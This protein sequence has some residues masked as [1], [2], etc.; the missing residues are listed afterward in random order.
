M[1]W[2]VMNMVCY[3]LVCYERDLLWTGL[4]WTWSVIKG[5]VMN[6]SVLSGLLWAGLFWTVTMPRGCMTSLW[7]FFREKPDLGYN[8]QLEW[9]FSKGCAVTTVHVGKFLH[10]KCQSWPQ[11]C[12]KNSNKFFDPFW[13]WHRWKDPKNGG[14]FCRFRL[15]VSTGVYQHKGEVWKS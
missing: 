7:R 10:K 2:S 13:G 15:W 8:Q 1:N 4:L 6:G 5:S 3:E 11:L 9:Y 12:N 14:V